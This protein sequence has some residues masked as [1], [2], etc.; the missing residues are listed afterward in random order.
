MRTGILFLNFG[1]PEH[2]DPEEVLPFLERIFLRNAPLEGDLDPERM[3][4]RSR[5]LAGRRAPGLVEEY[6]AIGGSPLN[7]QARAQAA[8]VEEELRTRGREVRSFT[9]MQFTPP[10]V[11]DA[12]LQA[13]EEGVERLVALPVYP[14]CGASTTVAALED[15]RDAVDGLGWGV[16]LLEISGWHRHPEYVALHADHVRAF[17]EGRGLS[18]GDPGTRL[19]FSA[20]GT[21]IRYLEEGSRY[22]LYVEE[23]CSDLAA[24]LGVQDALTGFQNH[25]NRPIEWTQPDV[26]R[27]IVELEAERAV[28]VAVSF[29]HEQSETLAELDGELAEEAAGAGVEMHRVPV[30]H[31]DPRFVR[32]LADLIEARVGWPASSGAP[33]TRSSGLPPMEPCRCRSHRDTR[34]LNAGPRKASGVGAAG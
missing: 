2:P 16:E 34:C 5:E 32:L 26:E 22:D 6:R 17:V 21:P 4:E 1:E 10:F 13:R 20:H 9:G 14:L 31:D 24:A 12:V 11:A 19:V 3:R 7:A 33:G 23:L 30:P 8:A 27:V 25:G 15:A 28:V 29:M 18:L